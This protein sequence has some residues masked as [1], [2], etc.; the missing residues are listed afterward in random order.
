[1]ANSFNAP[2]MGLGLSEER[3]A[4]LQRE[5]RL[6]QELYAQQK[7][8]Q[9]S[10][11]LERSNQDVDAY[12]ESQNNVFIP[13]RNA[14][15]SAGQNVN[16]APSDGSASSA[17]NPSQ[18]EPDDLD[19]AD[20]FSR[21]FFRTRDKTVSKRR[22][23]FMALDDEELDFNP[24]APVQKTLP[25]YLTEQINL[26]VKFE[27][28]NPEVKDLCYK[29]IDSL[30]PAG[31]FKVTDDQAKI[32][33]TE[34]LVAYPD[35]DDDELLAINDFDNLFDL[36]STRDLRTRAKK[37][38]EDYYAVEVKSKTARRF[39]REEFDA[40]IG[41]KTTKEERDQAYKILAKINTELP[42]SDPLRS[43]FST[44]PSPEELNLASQAL[45][46]VQSL[47]PP[48]VGARDLR[49]SLLLRLRPDAKNHDVLRLLIQDYF[50][51]F[52][53]KRIGV[54]ASKTHLS[55]DVI[56]QIYSAPFPFEPSPEELFAQPSAPTRWI[57]PEIYVTQ[58]E[59]G[60]W[61]VKLDETKEDLELDPYYRKLLISKHV[62]KKTKEYLKR[63]LVEAQALVDALKNRNTTLLRVAKA[64][65]DFQQSYFSDPTSHLK[66]LT[67]QVIADKLGLDSSTVS[68]ACNDKWLSSP[69]G[70]VPLKDMFPKAVDGETTSVGISEK[71]R[72]LIDHEDKA[73]PLSDEDITLQLKRRYSIEVSR[74]TVQ[75]HRDR[76]QIPNS[77][78]RKRLANNS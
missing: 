62:D 56:S 48:G 68:R 29:I 61:V 40:I 20:F 51:D 70:Y 42:Q 52:I 45:A 63:Q 77:R 50:D 73:A 8:I 71:I 46:I 16:G 31:Y 19:G 34:N 14:G 39:A 37:A 72:E 32:L 36:V 23:Q 7:K 54:L 11:L 5:N 75:E 47:D 4:T 6:K 35:E 26:D 65:V 28:L 33:A 27:G 66:P 58:N 12:I 25:E 74:K 21:Q 60:K 78:A 9:F 22:A 41:R 64:I 76:L 24:E 67:Q 1:M 15:E 3:R 30:D 49:E 69:R 59:L 2:R 18:I 10:N 53:K 13:H 38:L 44:P 17:D 55:H 57:Q 43:L